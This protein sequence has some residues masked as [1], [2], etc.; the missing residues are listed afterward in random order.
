MG[1]RQ[2]CNCRTCTQVCLGWEHCPRWNTLGGWQVVQVQQPP[3]VT[4]THTH[5]GGRWQVGWGLQVGWQQK[6]TRRI[7]LCNNVLG[8]N[9]TKSH[10]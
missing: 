1:H 3:Q 6:Q 7:A 10:R 4:A 9:P 8:K 2:N 5:N